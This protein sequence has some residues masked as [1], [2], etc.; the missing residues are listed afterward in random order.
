[1]LQSL[2]LHV[3]WWETIGRQVFLSKEKGIRLPGQIKNMKIRTF[4]ETMTDFVKACG[5]V[6]ITMSISKVHQALEDDT[7][8]IAMSSVATLQTRDLWQVTKAITRTDHASI[9]FLVII[10]EKTWKSLSESQRQIMM[11]AARKVER[12]AR[13]R[14]AQ[15][16]E[17]AY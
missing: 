13:L 16:E 2:G 10:N 12:E 3:L 17:A 8:D 6:P 11:K 14:A 4:S 5:G 15:L 1:V 9:E 7:L